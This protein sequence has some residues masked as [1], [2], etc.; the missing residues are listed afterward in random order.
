MGGPSGISAGG[1]GGAA[2]AL[3]ALQNGGTPGDSATGGA[4]RLRGPAAA[5]AVE[6]GTRLP[7][8]RPANLEPATTDVLSTSGTQRTGRQGGGTPIKPGDGG[9]PEIKFPRGALGRQ[10]GGTPIQPGDVDGPSP[11][12]IEGRQGSGHVPRPDLAVS[13]VGGPGLAAAG[14]RVG[15][16]TG[17][18]IA[19]EMDNSIHHGRQGSGFTGKPGEPGGRSPIAERL[20]ADAAEALAA[21]AKADGRD[22]PDT[23]SARALVEDTAAAAGVEYAEGELDETRHREQLERLE[24]QMS[25]LTDSTREVVVQTVADQLPPNADLSDVIRELL[26]FIGRTA[27]RQGGG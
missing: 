5:G 23:A 16:L 10:G 8:G 22:E 1:A 25:L 20:G 27:G 13:G 19:A 4:R 11:D 14:Q 12:R 17:A 15:A 26:E 3:T 21:A 18:D 24:Q 6:L 7:G 2:S 9:A